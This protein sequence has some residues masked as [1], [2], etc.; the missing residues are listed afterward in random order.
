MTAAP[1]A[2]LDQGPL[3]AFDKPSGVP[4]IPGRGD[5]PGASLLEIASALEGRK[6]FVVHRLDRGTSGVLLFARDA[7]AHRRLNALFESRAVRKTYLAWVLGE[8]ASEE[9]VVEVPLRSFGSG[10]EGVAE[11]GKPSLTHWKVLRRAPG[12]TLLE[13]RPETGR[14]HQIRV[15]LFSLGHPVLGDDLYGAPRPVG[16]A[17]RLMLHALHLS[18]PWDAPTPLLI[19]APPPPDFTP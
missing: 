19:S 10:R 2:V 17:P 14:R 3:V 8:L 13:V 11:G 18:F 12:K 1:A 5:P 4:S 6:L 7:A 9:G 15:H 16:A